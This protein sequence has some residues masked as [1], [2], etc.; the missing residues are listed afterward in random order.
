MAIETQNGKA[1]LYGISNSGSP[2]TIEGYASFILESAKV[3]RKYDM[4]VVKDENNFDAALIWTNGH[5]EVDV[6]FVVSGATRD[7]AAATAV[8]L[9]PGAKVTMANFKAAVCNGDWINLGDQSLDLTQKGPAKMTLKLRRYV[10]T[11][12]ND[13]LT[14][15]VS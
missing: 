12:Q 4:E 3:G 14:T 7:S 13:S 15:T 10:D 6:P 2:I 9:S 8:F 11:D 5:D 1:T